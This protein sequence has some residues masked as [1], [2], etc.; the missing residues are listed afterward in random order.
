MGSGR[1]PAALSRDDLRTD[2][3]I[4]FGAWPE[5]AA[6]STPGAATAEP[7]ARAAVTASD[8]EGAVIPAQ[9]WRRPID[10]GDP[11]PREEPDI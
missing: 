6:S 1:L 11:L 8:A 3:V 7:G 2:P 5:T 4:P 9:R 10:G